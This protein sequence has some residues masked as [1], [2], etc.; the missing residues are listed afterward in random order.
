MTLSHLNPALRSLWFFV[1]TRNH[2][3][4]HLISCSW[5]SRESSS[6]LHRCKLP[7]AAYLKVLQQGASS[8]LWHSPFKWSVQPEE[9]DMGLS[10][11]SHPIPFSP[12]HAAKKKGGRTAREEVTH[13]FLFW[14]CSQEKGKWDHQGRHFPS[15]SILTAQLSPPNH[16]SGSLLQPFK[17]G[18]KREP[19]AAK[20][21]QKEG[22]GMPFCW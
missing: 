9:R 22:D 14:P 11:K 21:A 2:L 15:P 10:G 13:V 17:P 20:P 12:G 3:N 16:Q 19:E 4:Q 1:R 18:C 5:Y 6:H 8:Y 7:S